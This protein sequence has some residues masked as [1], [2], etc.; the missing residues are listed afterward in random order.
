MN[1]WTSGSSL[2]SSASSGAA[3]E[4]PP[5]VQHGEP[6]ADDARARNV[7]RDDHERGAALLRLDEQL[8]DLAGR[9]R[10]EAGTRL[11][12]EQD[13]RVERHGAGEPG[14]L[15]HPARQVARHLVEVLLETDV[16]ELARRALANVGIG[17]VGVAPHRKRHVVA[18]RHR[19]E[20]RRVLKEEA[21]VLPHVGQLAPV[22]RR[23]V[24]FLD[25]HAARCRAAPARRCGG[26]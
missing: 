8:V 5:L 15:L 22:E 12:H 2:A 26:G 11:V 23:D 4:Q 1:A 18:D 21:H 6:V 16:R 20:Q 24:A 3:R 17:P 19:V 10:I 14:P 25:E 13:R 7:V 9:N